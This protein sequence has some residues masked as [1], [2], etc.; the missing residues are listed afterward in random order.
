[1]P[2][3]SIWAPFG[4]LQYTSGP[5]TAETV[6]DA[7]LASEGAGAAF[8]NDWDS[9]QQMRNYARAMVF[10]GAKS[11]TDRAKNNQHPNTATELLAELERD[12]GVVPLDGQ[13]LDERRAAVTA[14]KRVVEGA[15]EN[16]IEAQL[17]AL[18]GGDFVSYA[19][20]ASP[21]IWPEVADLATIA[22]FGRVRSQVKVLRLDASVPITGSPIT[23][24]YT[25]LGGTEA[26]QAGDVLTFDPDPKK[27]AEAVTI[28]SAN[29]TTL[30]ASFAKSHDP[31]A[32]GMFPCPLWL[33][34]QRTAIIT[35]TL[36]A[37]QDAVTRQRV[38]DLMHRYARGVSTWYILGV[39]GDVFTPDTAPLS[40]PDIVPLG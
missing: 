21:E 24:P 28:T 19:I 1:M 3:F 30:T 34:H 15:A 11:Q 17:T 31:G 16:V 8:A 25:S 18:L 9:I 7:M 40:L 5:P 2:Q 29:S 27:H 4:L 37:S 39:S 6:Y 33:S 23:V 22:A 35:L 32:Y 38:H 12:Y 10:A 26:P 14:R 13:S 20:V 36:S